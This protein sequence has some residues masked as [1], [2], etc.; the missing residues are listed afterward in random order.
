MGTI[1]IAAHMHS[2]WGT[3]SLR[4]GTNEGIA[5]FILRTTERRLRLSYIVTIFIPSCVRLLLFRFVL[6]YCFFIERAKMFQNCTRFII[7]SRAITF[8]L[9]SSLL[10]Q[11]IKWHIS[12]IVWILLCLMW[13][14]FYFISG[15]WHNIQFIFS[16][17]TYAVQTRF[18]RWFCIIL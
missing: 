4:C 14:V 10:S 16:Y 7:V 1:V 8:L 17:K 5:G 11:M 6:Q 9:D 3:F 18:S 13:D 12:T 2:L 15:R